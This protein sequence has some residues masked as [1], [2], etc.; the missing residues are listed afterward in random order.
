MRIR[1]DM[2]QLRSLD[3]GL[4][5]PTGIV[6]GTRW[7]VIHIVWQP[8]I[9]SPDSATISAA[10]QEYGKYIMDLRT[11]L[12][13]NAK[14]LEAA[15]KIPNNIVEANSIRDIGR[16]LLEALYQAIRIPVE[17]GHPA[18]V[19]VLGG[20]HSMV[21]SLTTT[22]IECN[23]RN[24]HQGPLPKA[25]FALLAK[26]Q[27]MTDDLLRRCKFEGLQKKWNKVGDAETK[28]HIESIL[29]NT[30]DAQEKRAKAEEA[31]KQKLLDEQKE[32][33]RLEQLRLRTEN[34]MTTNSSKRPPEGDGSNGKP[35]KKSAAEGSTSKVAPK[36]ST[37][38][39]A[40]NLL[41]TASKP[42]SKPVIPK[43]QE[44]PPTQSKLGAL[45]SSIAKPPEAPKPPSPPPRAPETPEEQARRERKESRRHL[46]VKFKEGSDLVEIRLFRHEVAEDEGRDM[47]MLRD[48]HDNRSEGLMLKKGRQESE[49]AM[50]EA[51]DSLN[52]PYTAPIEADFSGLEKNTRYGPTWITRGG[53]VEVKTSE[54]AIQQRRE[55]LELMVIYNDINEMPPTP[56]EPPVAET[57]ILP[58][59]HQIGQPT[60]PW[61]VQRLQE[62]NHYGPEVAKQVS[63]SRMQEQQSRNFSASTPSMTFTPQSQSP[64]TLSTP[65]YDM[66]NPLDAATAF[67]NLQRIV[68][69]I[70]GKPYPPI[71]PPEYMNAAQKADWWEGY[72][73]DY[74][75]KR[76]GQAASHPAP[77]MSSYQPVMQTP[78]M[79]M[80]TPQMSA[81]HMTPQ[82][83]H[84]PQMQSQPHLSYNVSAPVPDASQQVQAYLAAMTAYNAPNTANTSTPTT[85]NKDPDITSYP[86]FDFASWSKDPQGYTQRMHTL[87]QSQGRESSRKREFD[88]GRG[89]GRDWERA[90]D[91]DSD[92][93]APAGKRRRF[94]EH[95][96]YIGKKLP[97]KFYSM[98]KCAKGDQCT[99]L[100]E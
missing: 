7:D 49:E 38:L 57:G 93:D 97:C 95:G 90:G 91:R 32:K 77:M 79:T 82:M 62:I 67:A 23:K 56:K 46:R 81:P 89:R 94:N 25:V 96:E 4:V 10:L 84:Y 83:Q 9:S 22:L 50:D 41:G 73:R 16:D 48:A 18:V 53:N 51:D 20:H 13:A 11:R 28:E 37:N 92:E 68:D 36:R 64:A 31:R 2:E 98:G 99:F 66:N 47:D 85:V 100:H 69:S 88:R 72:Y 30:V 26:F 86:D 44:A 24:D 63:L 52:R 70:K 75:E 35:A 45:L 40:N 5:R 8:R 15:E 42:S 27:T 71:E 3:L 34:A 59:K 14:E 55:A 54:Q 6:E 19:E 12:K 1:A 78:Q 58:E 60:A 80:P 61:L 74:P 39:L 65:K 29:H 17:D 43:R 21:A 33:E 76:P 87:H